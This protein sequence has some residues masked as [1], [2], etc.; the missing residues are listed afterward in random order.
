MTSTIKSP[1]TPAQTHYE[2]LGIDPRSTR[3]EGKQAYLHIALKNHSDKQIGR[4]LTDAEKEKAN[5]LFLNANAAHSTKRRAR[6]MTRNAT[7]S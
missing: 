7:C 2:V 4:D 3:A 5:A 1:S 6:N